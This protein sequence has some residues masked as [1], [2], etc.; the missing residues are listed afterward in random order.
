MITRED[1]SALI[2]LLSYRICPPGKVSMGHVSACHFLKKGDVV[3]STCYECWEAYL[4]G[5]IDVEPEKHKEKE[6]P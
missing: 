5:L 4:F 3:T 1:L 2:T 6:K